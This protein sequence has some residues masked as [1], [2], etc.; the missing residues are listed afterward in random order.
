MT[1]SLAEAP[2]SHLFKSNRLHDPTDVVFGWGETPH[3]LSA[4]AQDPIALDIMFVE[5]D[6][7]SKHGEEFGM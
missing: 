7:V 5:D 6:E 2:M 3:P 4:H 1:K